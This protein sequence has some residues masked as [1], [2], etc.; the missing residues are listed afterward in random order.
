MI[1]QKI[2]TVIVNIYADITFQ[3]D[4]SLTIKTKDLKCIVMRQHVKTISLYLYQV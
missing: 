3:I 4:N 2:T 1:N